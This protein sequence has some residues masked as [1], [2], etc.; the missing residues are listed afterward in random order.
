MAWPYNSN[1]YMQPGQFQ[2]PQ[3]PYGVMPQQP[4]MQPTMQV[5]RV[6]GRGG[7]EA[8]SIGPNSSALLLDESGRLVWAVTTDG[9]GYKTISPYDIVPHQD[10]P[11]PDIS[12]LESRIARLEGI[13]SE[14]SANTPT[15]RKH[16]KAAESD[17]G[18]D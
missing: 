10:A 9:A 11:A 2:Q 6:N 15:A 7:A 12:G 18:A 1:P 13:V 17:D 16:G 4:T 3:S 8:F 5:V 14:Y